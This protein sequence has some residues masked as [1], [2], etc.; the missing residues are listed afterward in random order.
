MQRTL[1]SEDAKDSVLGELGGFST[2]RYSEDSKDCTRRN[3][4]PL[5]LEVLRGFKGL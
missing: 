1:Y 3:Q 4:R 5:Y 2:Q